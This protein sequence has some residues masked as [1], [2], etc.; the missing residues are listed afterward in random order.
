MANAKKAANAKLSYAEKFNSSQSSGKNKK[1]SDDYHTNKS[2]KL[3]SKA[4]GIIRKMVAVGDYETAERIAN[5]MERRVK[6][7][8]NPDGKTIEER[9]ENVD[10]WDSTG[11][12]EQRSADGYSTAFDR[13]IKGGFDG[14]FRR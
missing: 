1:V 14:Y 13:A 10:V 2:V 6:R 8:Y 3:F 11:T 5:E 12:T 9:L 7:G 4:V